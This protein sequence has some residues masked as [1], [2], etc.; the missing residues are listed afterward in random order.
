MQDFKVTVTGETGSISYDV[1]KTLRGAKGFAKRL[2]SE[3]FYGEEVQ[4]T[5]EAS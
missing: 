3:A 4:I 1:F 5:I 2:A